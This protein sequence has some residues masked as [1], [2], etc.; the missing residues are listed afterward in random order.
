MKSNEIRQINGF[1]N[2]SFFQVIKLFFIYCL[3]NNP[4]FYYGFFPTPRNT[5][6]NSI[7]SFYPASQNLMAIGM[8]FFKLIY[9]D[10]SRSLNNSIV[11]FISVNCHKYYLKK[12]IFINKSFGNYLF[13]TNHYK[14]YTGIL[15]NP[16]AN[17][18]GFMYCNLIES[19]FKYSFFILISFLMGLVLSLSDI[20]LYSIQ[21]YTNDIHYALKNISVLF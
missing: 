14:S 15:K 2:K 7:F 5:F 12:H 3:M 19:I 1:F 9:I 8:Q 16:I 18:K 13:M 11:I 21:E 17:N 6:H 20:E 4:V 10:F